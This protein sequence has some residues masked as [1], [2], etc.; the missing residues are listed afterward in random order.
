M[1]H[2]KNIL[3][4]LFLFGFLVV[5]M[6]FS[7][8][9]GAMNDYCIIPPFI[10][11][12]IP[13]NILIVLDNSGS[14]NDQAYSGT[15]DPT[16]FAN[17]Q[18]YGY[19]DATKNYKYTG[20]GR[21]EP[22]VEPMT[23][24]TNAN[25]IASGNFLTWATTRRIDAAKKL[26]IG[27]KASPRS[28]AGAVTVK[29]YGENS[30]TSW[31]FSKDFDN[32]TVPGLIFP[33][34]GNYRYSMSG[35]Q[36][37]ITPL[38]AGA[39]TENV[40]PNSDIVNGAWVPNA[41]ATNWTQVAEAAADADTTYIQNTTS[42]TNDQ[43]ILGYKP[44][45]PAIAGSI[46]NVTIVVRA[47]KA[48]TSTNQTRRIQAVIRMKGGASDVDYISNYSNLSTTYTNY[49][50][51]WATNP[52]TGLNWQFA[53]L[54]GN[55]VGS[56]V[57]FGI[58]AYTTPT[59]ANYPRATQ[60]YMIVTVSNPSGGPYNL[61]VDQ[62]MVKA[63][64]IIDGLSDDV[65]F[66][67]TYY[68]TS[69]GAEV[70]TYVNF[71]SPVNMITSI[72]NMSP[73]TWTPL[74]ETMYEM[75]R[76]YRQDNPYYPNA[77]ADFQTG[78]NYD[79]YYF[80]YSDPAI[81]DAYVP[82][83]RSYI[84]FLT[85]GESTQDLNIPASIRGYSAG[86]RY[87]GTAVGTTYASSGTDYLIDVAF[88][89][90]TN[91]MR[92]GV[93]TTTPT[94]WQTCLPGTQNII[95]YPVFMFGRGSTLL[96]DAA[97][98]GGFDDLNGNNTPDCNTIASECYRDTDSDGVVESNGQDNPLAYYEGDDGYEL[99]KNLIDA[100]NAI[101]RRAASGTAASVLASGEGT[102][103]NL[104]Q[105]IFYPKRVFN[106]KEIS[107]TGTLQS[108]WYYLDPYVNRSTIRED[109]VTD[110]E[111]EIDQDY[112]LRLYF[113][114]AEQRTKA[115]RF[116]SDKF[117]NPIM[118]QEASRYIEELDYIWESG[119]SLQSRDIGVDPRTIYVNKD[120]PPSLAAFTTGNAAALQT[121]LQASTLA[122]AQNI[123]AYIRG[124]S[125]VD[126]ALYRNRTVT[127]KGITGIWRLG[128]V[129]D[130]TTKVVSWVP[131]NDYDLAY[132]DTTYAKFLASVKYTNRGKSK[133]G[134]Y[135]GSGVVFAGANDGML[136]AFTLGALELVNDGTTKK[137]AIRGPNLGR[138][139]WAFI[140]KNSLPYLRYLMC[141]DSNGDVNC[142]NPA[143]DY[144]HVYFIDL[145]TSIVDVSINSPAG[146]ASANYWECQRDE[147]SWRTVLVGGMKLGGG[148]KPSS[149]GSY[150]Y[151]VRTP[152]AGEGYSS[153]FALDITDY[154]ANY[155][156]DP[157]NHPPQLL[158][159]FTHPDLGFST[160]GPSFIRI[161]ARDVQGGISKA[162]INKNGR[163]FAV[164]ASGP[165]GP[166]D[167]NKHEFK[168]F[169][170]QTLKV[171]ILDL[172]T[173]LPAA[174]V[175]DTGIQYAFASSIKR[176]NI[177]YD[178]DYQDD[179]L[180]F[181]YLKAEDN[182]PVAST[183]WNQGGVLRII[184][185]EDLSGADITAGG[186]TALNPA[187]WRWSKVID[188]I[189]P[190]SAPV[191]HIAH[192]PSKGLPPDAG[193]LFFGTGRYF[194]KDDDLGVPNPPRR[195]YG[196]K[197][198]CLRDA[199]VLIADPTCT[200]DPDS[201]FCKECSVPIS[202]YPRAVGVFDNATLTGLAADAANGWFI[203]LDTPERLTSTPSPTRIGIVFFATMS[204]GLELCE[205]G[206]S[207]YLW[208]MQ[209]ARA[210]S[211]ADSI[212]GKVLMQVSSG[213]IEEVDL[214]SALT[215]KAKRRTP[216]MV[217][218]PPEDSPAITIPPEGSNLILH[219][220]K[221]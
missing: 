216:P 184:T 44:Y 83:A 79:P 87:A 54:T 74:A 160:S 142:G 145:T 8:S 210:S 157:V 57:G 154:L 36:L 95:L 7:F 51:N 108:L 161:N 180:Y 139:E 208:A 110:K 73:T 148:C 156:R 68:N 2:N 202:D 92:P 146:C 72:Q 189:G 91:D 149:G 178:L 175:L 81:T 182:P 86:Y 6:T 118:P 90:R 14:M 77:P 130:S 70:D 195:L 75:T 38:V 9:E 121:R 200:T 67:L 203:D 134:V 60:I 128:D 85:D 111:L 50:F 97:I 220:R 172:K 198:P 58:K 181:G 192:Y 153:Y 131:L 167:T 64:G 4:K 194:F 109:T 100:I 188:N 12:T 215:E 201:Q 21:W 191:G 63:V 35:D 29:I 39:S 82:C 25:P 204:P 117:G 76:Y 176:A 120:G 199:T 80:N 5:L 169:S 71:G 61:I 26:L 32:T 165:T 132:N 136:H 186:A 84:L 99:E 221:K 138:E 93:C 34:T 129:I 20:N 126:S 196:I 113:N 96:K 152:M 170:D 18:Y 65:R 19:F 207:T 107:W 33:F 159:E 56:M 53:D 112:I 140:P 23:N 88:W 89:A 55:A 24:G 98:D 218:L 47:K 163:W 206:G 147:T 42:S 101:L 174:P 30:P 116:K 45:A 183:K 106:E 49:S 179:A 193:W 69:E 22:T 104:V 155:P 212:V 62:G 122:E 41:G 103:A 15:Y 66:G 52:Q 219:I 48:G 78:L 59:A 166:I 205:Y 177:D 137:A 10:S 171:F 1:K 125:D 214:K 37:S 150:P 13:P 168:G 209:Y 105:A 115:D 158:W 3:T 164:F 141:K 27:G 197:D 40:R 46:T 151:G 94:S 28:P 185:R 43:V 114:Q 135:N 124:D 133:S 17:G 217:G 213:A 11:P 144:C 173:G 143:K 16:Q 187:N 162:N 211:V 190:V 127:N 102:G 119:G 123:I 31:N